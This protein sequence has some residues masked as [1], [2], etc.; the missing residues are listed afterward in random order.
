MLVVHFDRMKPYQGPHM[1]AW[2]TETPTRVTETPI[3]IDQGQSP[4][5]QNHQRGAEATL[6]DIGV[7]EDVRIEPILDMGGWDND[8]ITETVQDTEDIPVTHGRRNP[9]RERKLPLRFR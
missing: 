5:Q 4:E 6:S 2:H 9:L 1:D 3:Q 7:D 8:V